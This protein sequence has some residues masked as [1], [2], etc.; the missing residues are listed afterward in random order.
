MEDLFIA[1]LLQQTERT[2]L[3]NRVRMFQ[4][5]EGQLAQ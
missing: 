1:V 3:Q 2:E 5:W 4:N